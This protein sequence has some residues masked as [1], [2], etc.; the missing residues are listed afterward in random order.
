MIPFPFVAF[1][2]LLIHAQS[3]YLSVVA[4]TTSAI[5][6]SYLSIATNLSSSLRNL[7]VVGESGMRRL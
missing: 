3:G 1:D 7:A 4:L 2:T 5:G 6:G